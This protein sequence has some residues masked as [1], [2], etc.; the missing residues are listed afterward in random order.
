MMAR[1]SST[2]AVVL[3]M[4]VACKEEPTKPAP[5]PTC[6]PSQAAVL[7]PGGRSIADV[8]DQVT[9]SVVSV[10]SERPVQLAPEHLWP[11]DF[12]RPGRGPSRRREYSL[13]SGVIVS[14]NGV[15]VTNSHVVAQADKIRV[16]LKDGRILVAKVVGTDPKSDLAVLRVDAKNLTPIRVA[17]SSRLR[18]GDVVLAI[19]NPFGVGQTVT[20]GIVSAVGRSNVGITSY[21]DFIQTDAAI[22][23][24]NSGGALVDMQGQL[25]GI[26]IAIISRTG[27]YQGIGFAI[28][29]QMTM[30]I[31]DAILQHGKVIRGWLGVA[32]QDLTDELARSLDI[33]PRSGVL[34]SDVTPRSPAAKAGLERGDVITAIDGVKTI[35]SSQLRN[36]IALTAKGTKVRLDVLRNERPRSIEVV[37][38]EQPDDRSAAARPDDDAEAGGLF[39]GATVRDLD[40]AVRAHLDLPEALRGVVVI[41]V[42]PGSPAAFMGLRIGDVIMEVNRTKTPS[43]KSFRD[44]ARASQRRALVLVYREGAT[45]FISFSTEQE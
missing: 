19:G 26:N 22:N 14:A 35:D 12:D 7:F 36:R 24:G 15:I 9:P 1:T 21:D 4:L 23:P 45:I 43:V 33:P 39:A 27:G 42:A 8:A 16:A 6:P 28:P 34:V 25:V 5:T 41:A 18:T 44:A 29:S 40:P 11:Y 10:L 32:V 38:G 2:V 37:L 20:M 13:G 30:Q 3:A 31:K 17:D